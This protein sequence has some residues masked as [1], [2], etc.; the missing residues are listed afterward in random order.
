MSKIL[1]IEDENILAE[2]IADALEV[3]GHETKIVNTIS[4]A[5]QYLENHS[6][7]LILLDLALPDGS[8]LDFLD[9]LTNHPQAPTVIVLTANSSVSTVVQAIRRGAYDY[10]AKPFELDVLLHRI[11]NAI[12]HREG[13]AAKT[14]QLRLNE[15]EKQSKPLVAP[16]SKQMKEL[17]E[18]IKRIAVF[19]SMTVLIIGETGV[20]KEHICKLLHEL[21]PRSK[22]PFIAVNCATL[23]KSLLQSELFGHEKGAFTGATERRK[24]LFECANRGTLFLDEVSEMPMDIQASFLRVLESRHFRRLGGSLEIETNAR[25]LAATNQDLN[26]LV[27]KNKFREDLFFRLNQIEIH[28]PPLRTRPED[29]RILAEHF[30]NTLSRSLGIT[31][32]LTED[33]FDCLMQYSWPG[34]IRE[35]KNVIERT[36]IIKGTG[37]ISGQDFAL[38][39]SSINLGFNRSEVVS[40]ANTNNYKFMSLSEME[41]SHI[42]KALNIC[43]G[44][45]TQAAKLLGI[46]RSSLIRKLEELAKPNKTTK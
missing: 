46:A 10:L 19:D 30:C 11:E 7:N 27:H 17:Y 35:L 12:S 39:N 38:N 8:G 41:A 26:S 13:I 18:H 1:L 25:I 44:N 31:I 3:E 15:L 14:L 37:Q 5:K 43:S 20:G 24:G 33:A 42:E 4:S 32:S 28:I 29:I 9:F 2:S 34:N 16:L 36:V 22:E 23:D 6:S 45:R 21:S 40:R